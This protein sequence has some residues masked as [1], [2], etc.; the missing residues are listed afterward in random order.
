[1]WLVTVLGSPGLHMAWPA[2]VFPGH[3]AHSL[4]PWKAGE[5]WGRQDKAPMAL[6]WLKKAAM[7]TRTVEV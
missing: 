4:A 7:L 1:M 3:M 5:D 6:A 2:H